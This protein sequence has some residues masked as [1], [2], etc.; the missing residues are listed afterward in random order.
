[1]N[2]LIGES[3]FLQ[4]AIHNSRLT[5]S[6]CDDVPNMTVILIQIGI[7]FSEVTT[8]RT[9]RF[10][11]LGCYV[12]TYSNQSVINMTNTKQSI[13]FSQTILLFY[14]NYWSLVKEKR[15]KQIMG[16]HHYQGQASST[17]KISITLAITNNL[18]SWDFYRMHPL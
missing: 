9:W 13:N 15:E 12:S 16:S 10:F 1:M 5:K 4:K 8:H 17:R 14:L 7:V 11:V 6:L 18:W 2:N 3:F